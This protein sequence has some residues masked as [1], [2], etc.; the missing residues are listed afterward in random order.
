[1]KVRASANDNFEASPIAFYNFTIAQS[2]WTTWWFRLLALLCIAALIYWFLKQ[3]IKMIR[4]TEHSESEKIQLQYDALK[5]QVNPHF[6]FNSFNALLNIVEDDPKEASALIR[7]LSQFYRKM[8]AY[9]Q[10]ELITLEEELELLNSYLYIQ[11]K[12]YGS[13]LQVSV[14]INPDLKKST[15]IPPLVLQLLAENAVKHNTISKD[16]PLQI[17]IS[18]EGD[19]LIVRNNINHKLEK[20][21]SEGVGL[22]NIRNRYKFLIHREITQA[23]NNSEF[24]IRLPIIYSN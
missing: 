15:F 8:T 20:E 4:K 7:H 19:L 2:F 5:N 21:E 14:N 1:M 13:A 22:K 17:N 11:E 12:R 3:R 6:L 16:K 18:S 9:S 24:I 10:K 23:Q